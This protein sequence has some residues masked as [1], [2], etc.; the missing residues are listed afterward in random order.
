MKKEDKT[1]LSLQID[2]KIF[3]DLVRFYIEHRHLA[4]LAAKIHAYLIFDFSRK[5]VTF[6]EL[7]EVLASSKSSVSSNLNI[8]LNL[9][10]ITDIN[11]IDER[12][13]YFVI[14]SD[15]MKNYFQSITDKMEKEREIIRN[16]ES[17]Y[18]SSN[19]EETNGFQIFI[20]L[21]TNNINNIQSTVKEL[22]TYEK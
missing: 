7:V 10:L 18:K 11:R 4:P 14:N 20:N 6:D 2:E 19:H 13:R 5:G 3:Q 8:L 16:L 15:Y 21:L 9:G 1:V 22:S 17:F 12:K